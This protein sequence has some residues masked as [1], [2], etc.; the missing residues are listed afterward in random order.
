MEPPSSAASSLKSAKFHPMEAQLPTCDHLDERQFQLAIRRLADSLS[1]GTDSSPF[2]G[3]GIEY[4]QSRLYQPGDPIK[5]IDWRVTARTGKVHIKEYEAPK[6][7]P[8]YLLVDTSASM[9]VSSQPVSKYS[10]A[11]QL[12]GGLA[13][14]ALGR[15][16]PVAVIGVGDRE[17]GIQ[18][19]LSRDLVFMW[20]HALR[21]YRFDERTMLATR[22][23]K[24]AGAAENRCLVIVLS[25]LHDPDSLPALKLLAQEHDCIVLHLQDPAELGRI[26]GGIFRAREA[27]TGKHFVSHGGSRWLDQERAELELRQSGV[28]Q[29]QLRTDQSFLPRLR[30]FLRRRD[31][32]G[33]GA[34]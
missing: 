28:N 3:S 23:R 27:E 30:Q 4:V 21:R 9:C 17:L 19:T 16:S 12:A 7:M 13:L 32:L 33:K 1:Y 2:L 15:M 8:V 14:S 18:P 25:D 5:S 24:L 20:L 22:V 10:W 11:V 34:R 31:S 26:G 6:R 29:L